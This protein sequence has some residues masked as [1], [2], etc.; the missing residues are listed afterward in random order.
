MALQRGRT[1]PPGLLAPRADQAHMHAPFGGAGEPL[2]HPH[3]QTVALSSTI[4]PLPGSASTQ[5][6]N[7]R[8]MIP[9]CWEGV[10][11]CARQGLA[12]AWWYQ[13]KTFR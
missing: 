10:H 13:V 11:A 8:C 7:Q 12:A 2:P 9:C 4:S 3:H 5:R 1:R 6:L